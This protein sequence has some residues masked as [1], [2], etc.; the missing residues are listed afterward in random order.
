VET[1]PGLRAQTLRECYDG[2]LGGHFGRAEAGSLVRCLTFWV[3]PDRDFAEQVGTCQT[4]L[5]WCEQR[6]FLKAVSQPL[7]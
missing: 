6:H 1:L 3:G 2:P 5:A 4:C 7:C